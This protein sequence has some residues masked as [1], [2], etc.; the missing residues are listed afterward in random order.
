MRIRKNFASVFFAIA[1]AIAVPAHAVAPPPSA[2]SLA[3][4][5]KAYLAYYGRPAD[6]AGLEYWAARMDAEGQS[7]AAIIGAFGNSAEFAARYGGLAN[8]Q[9]VTKVY[10]QAL[11]RDP[12]PAGLAYYVGELNAGNRTLQTIT[13]DVINGA[14]TDPDAT[15]VANKI[16]AAWYFTTE[17]AAGCPYG[18]E[19]DGVNL[20]A[21][22]S[23]VAATVT[24]SKL[25]VDQRCG[26]AATFTQR[27]AARLLQQA[28]WGASL[29]EITRV[30]GIGAEAWLTEQFATPSPSYTDYALWNIAQNKTGAHGCPARN[31]NIGCPW[32]VNHPAI[33]KQVFEG[34]DQL[35]QRVA[36]ALLQTMVISTANNK[37]QDA[38]TGVPNYLDMLGR[39]GFGNFR[40]LLK[41]VT[42]HPAMGMYLDMMGSSREVPNENYPR[43]MLQLF[44]IGTVMLNDDGTPKKDAQGNT[45]PTYG[46]DVVQ[47]FARAF[48]G[49]THAD[50]DMT[51]SWK[52][53][54]PDEKW[55]VPMKPWTGRRCP[56]DGHWPAGN[57]A[58]WCN[59]ADPNKSYPPPHEPGTKK[60]LQY[61]GAPF[62]NLPANQTPEMDVD[63]AVDNV[64]NHPNVGPFIAKR[65]IQRLVTSNPT[66]AYVQRVAKVFNNNGGGVRG[67]MKAVIRAILLDGEARS[68]TLSQGNTFGKLREPMAKF[69]HLHRAFEA[70]RADGYYDTWDFSDPETLN[71]QPLRAPSVFNFYGADSAPPGPITQAGLVGPEFDLATT[72]AVAGFSEFTKW[73][74]F[75]GWTWDYL[76]PATRLVP[77]YDR[78]LSGANALADNPQAMVDELDLLLTAGNLKRQFRSDLVAVLLKVTRQA[79]ADQRYDRLRIAFWQIVNSAE[80]AVQR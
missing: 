33:Y 32:Q 59:L 70:R 20:L 18:M 43:E 67:D 53:Y 47:G 50:Q 49:W 60:L 3:Y 68:T 75:G 73:G 34:A 6:P 41:D 19:Q 15:V 72:S 55:T 35:R 52:F 74:I 63:N 26:L 13:L 5:Q 21:A 28:T 9:L 14:T 45:I 29:A 24:A 31:Q 39:D 16:A 46:E 78:Y 76:D 4:V 40:D 62:P 12:D 77:N 66:P 17:V 65:L 51:K 7:L 27:G 2:Y 37:V 44:S 80:Y 1:A 56:Q 48:T 64:F 54:W 69:F 11:G 42:L 57:V 61:A 36:N 22:V 58:D 25:G 71:Q 8:A 23:A 38:G 79:I 10:Q 30:A